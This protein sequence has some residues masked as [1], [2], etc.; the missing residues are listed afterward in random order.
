MASIRTEFDINLDADRAWRVIG[1]WAKGPVGM[2]CGHV[3]SSQAD[4]DIRVVAFATGKV[5]RE[6]LIAHDEEMRRIVYSLIGGT[7]TPE[8]DNAV[9]QIVPGDSGRCRFAWSRDVLP[10][11]LAGPLHAAM[12][13]ASQVI[14]RT[15]DKDSAAQQH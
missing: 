14:K 12:E 9:M 2:A 11:E 3:V 8:H 1:D 4:G 7:V 15:L 5:A 6:R 10:D 13:E